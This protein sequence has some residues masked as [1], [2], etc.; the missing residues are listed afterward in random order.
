MRMRWPG[1]VAVIDEEVAMARPWDYAGRMEP[2]RR[3]W[4]AAGV[5]RPR[6]GAGGG[7]P[8]TA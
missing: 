5:A 3:F 7:G 8:W 1:E 4:D 6:A 2:I